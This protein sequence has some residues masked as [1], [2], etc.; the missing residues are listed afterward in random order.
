M[1]DI[2]HPAFR[3]ASLSGPRRRRIRL[4]FEAQHLQFS[5]NMF[6]GEPVDAASWPDVSFAQE[7]AHAV[8]DVARQSGWKRGSEQEGQ[9]GGR[10]EEMIVAPRQ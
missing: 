4:A 7:V 10:G 6:V 5:V 1:R 9:F 2:P 3:L 8:I